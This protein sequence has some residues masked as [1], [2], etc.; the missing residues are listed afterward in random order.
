M[1]FL[2]S[3]G[4]HA[5]PPTTQQQ[6]QQHQPGYTAPTTYSPNPAGRGRKKAL[7]IACTYPGTRAALRGPGND[8]SCMEYLLRSKFGFH[9][10]NIVVL[11]DDN[12]SRCVPWLVAR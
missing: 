5:H 9:A 6:Q 2:S 11:R 7:I 10:S 1:F 3:Q 8:A 4:S 12:I